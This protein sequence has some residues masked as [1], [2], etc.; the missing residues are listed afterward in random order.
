VSAAWNTAGVKLE[1]V[2]ERTSCWEDPNPRFRVYLFDGPGATSYATSTFDVVGADVLEVIRWAQ[3]QAGDERL[4]ALALV[5][6]AADGDE[7]LVWLVGMDAN[8]T[9]ETP[10]DEAHKAAMRRR[11]GR[12]IVTDG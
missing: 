1:P 6:T 5:G 9:A 2:D 8:D 12:L 4:Y 7:G 10:A 3:T 11:R